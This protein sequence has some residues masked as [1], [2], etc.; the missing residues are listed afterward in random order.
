[1]AAYCMKHAHLLDKS[2]PPKARLNMSFDQ[3]IVFFAHLCSPT[4]YSYKSGQLV[5]DSVTY[6]NM[7]L[8]EYGHLGV[9][10]PDADKVVL[11][12]DATARKISAMLAVRTSRMSG[13]A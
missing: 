3:L 2:L 6:T 9:S 8:E 7:S 12:D 1:M 11:R 13:V 10:F 5:F 4:F